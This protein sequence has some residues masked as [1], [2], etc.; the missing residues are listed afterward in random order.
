MVLSLMEKAIVALLLLTLIAMVAER[1]LLKVTMDITPADGFDVSVYGD[2]VDNIGNSQV[3]L[4]SEESWEWECTLSKD[5]ISFPYCGFE[6]IL[7]DDRTQGLDLRNMRNVR[8]WL[9]Y[10][11]PADSVRLYLRN[12][13]PT[14]SQPLRFDSTKYNLAEVSAKTAQGFIDVNI[15]DFFVANWW[16]Q[17]FKLSPNL[18]HPQ[19]DNIVVFEVQTGNSAPAGDYRFRLNKVLLTGQRINSEQ[20]YQLILGSWIFGAIALLSSRFIGMNRRI[21]QHRAREI[22]L[23]QLNSLLD[24]HGKKMEERSKLDPLTGAFNRQGVKEALEGGLAERRASGRSLS[25]LILDVDYFK[26]INDTHGHLIGDQVLMALSELI[27]QNTRTDD[28]FARW[29][30]EEFV[31]VCRNTRVQNAQNIA[32]KLRVAIENFRFD[33]KVS[34]TVSIGVAELQE[35]ETLEQM[36]TRADKALYEAKSMGRNRVM[37][38]P[39]P[40]G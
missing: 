12:Y 32:E 8:V 17:R 30:G 28:C 39:N 21:R 10:E 27:K 37:V 35:S 33:K 14:Y 3:R 31:V 26:K 40:H 11:G 25:I 18:T 1:K 16:F 29:G 22:E 34:F 23:T 24:A 9:D 4:L 38:A 5:K 13:D 15:E 20:W 36:F 7:S 19:F 2:Y 6:V